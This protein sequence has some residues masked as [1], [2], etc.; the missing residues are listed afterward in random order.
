[1]FAAGPAGK[2][3]PYRIESDPRLPSQKPTVRGRRRP[4]PLAG[5]FDQ[6]VIPLLKRTPQL[7]AVTIFE[8]LLRRHPDL[9]PSV[10][11]TLERR[12]C[13]AGAPCTAPIRA[14]H[15][16]DSLSAAFHNLD[17]AA[18][19]DDRALCEH[20]RM[21]PTR[22]NRGVSH[23]NGSVESAHGHL[24]AR[25]S[26]RRCCCAARAGSS[27]NWW[28]RRNAR[29]RPRIDA[30]TRRAAAAAGA[31]RPHP[32]CRATGLTP[33]WEQGYGCR[34]VLWSMYRHRTNRPLGP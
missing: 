3:V 9:A 10:R 22:N 5:I 7:R 1:M 8:E 12:A 30:E 26:T 21:R 19:H 34:R 31:P 2:G 6:E 17:R 4:D 24:Q 20:Y 25:S 13:A 27:P 11:R 16:T 32:D 14:E 29:H 18:Q 23:E 33:D 15:R 28:P